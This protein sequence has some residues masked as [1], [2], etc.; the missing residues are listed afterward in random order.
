MNWK[1]TIAG[2]LSF[3]R[4]DRIGVV[5]LVLLIA[6][7]YALPYLAAPKVP[8]P[9]ALNPLV[10]S[11]ATS[12]P[13]AQN[14]RYNDRSDFDFS[15]QP[16]V[17]E[18]GFSNGALFSFDPNTLD[19]AGWRRLGL[20][21]K[22]IRTI[23]NYRNKGGKFYKPTDLQKIWGLPQGF[24]DRVAGHIAI[25]PPQKFAKENTFEERKP[26][27]KKSLSI[28]INTADTSAWI[29][30][31]GIGSKLAGRIVNFRTKLGGFASVEQV[32]TTFGLPDSTFQKIKSMLLLEGKELVKININTATKEALSAHPYI[33]WKL[34]N[35]VVAYREQHGA[36]QSIEDLKKIMIL[37]DQVLNQLRPYLTVD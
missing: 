2:Y 15:P 24:Y 6:I 27:E 3:S 16:S 23:M 34:A 25:A 21:E 4:K 26:F 19:E 20:R 35:A 11:L 17:R 10:D 28:D 14:A 36:F 32:G 12:L 1:E 29:A 31:P 7:V 8:A 22:T 13:P 18:T 33:N 9:V 37:D 30:L 5:C